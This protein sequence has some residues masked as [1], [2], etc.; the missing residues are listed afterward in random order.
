MKSSK[1]LFFLILLL[2]FGC[3]K[4]EPVEVQVNFEP[5]A[6]PCLSQENA[7]FIIKSKE[8]YFQMVSQIYNE[9]PI[10]NCVDTTITP[11]SFDEY[12][13]LGRYLKYYLKDTITESV[14]ENRVEKTLIY[15]ISRTILG[16]STGGGFGDI[17]S[18]G[19]NWIKV[20]KPPLDYT[21]IILYQ[22]H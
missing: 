18:Q 21:C 6:L 2:F 13:L 5:V 20:T 9:F 7:Q 10:G 11:F 3:S 16:G 14:I 15:T 4:D 8:E 12:V 19:M 22:E 17:Q 1:Y